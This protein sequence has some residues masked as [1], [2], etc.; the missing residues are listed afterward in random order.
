[1]AIVRITTPRYA[2][3]RAHKKHFL[4]PAEP[5]PLRGRAV[6]KHPKLARR[7]VEAGELAR[8]AYR[9]IQ[10]RIVLIEREW[11]EG[12]FGRFDG[13]HCSCARLSKLFGTLFKPCNEVSTAYQ[14]LTTSVKRFGKLPW[15]HRRNQ[16]RLKAADNGEANSKASRGPRRSRSGA[17][18]FFKLRSAPPAPYRPGLRRAQA[19]RSH[20]S[21]GNA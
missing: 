13:G 3:L 21:S 8:V 20:D 10:E 19:H 5:S 7:V 12:T 17:R 14:T 4:S 11:R 18:C 16:G 6:G 1:M 2:Q 9:H 15:Q